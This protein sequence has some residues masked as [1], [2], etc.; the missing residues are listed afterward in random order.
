MSSCFQCPHC[1]RDNFKTERGLEQ[2][3]N[4]HSVCS[5]RQR[6]LDIP[7]ATLKHS[8]A[9]S[10]HSVTTKRCST[11]EYSSPKQKIRGGLGGKRFPVAKSAYEIGAN[12]HS[13]PQLKGSSSEDEHESQF[14]YENDFPFLDDDSAATEDE[15]DPNDD[16]NHLPV[17][18]ETLR[19]FQAYAAEGKQHFGEFT[20]QEKAGIKLM[21]T[22]QK[23]RLL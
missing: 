12:A 10:K 5:Q 22:L 8:F 16:Q 1:L 3:L 13:G 2:H 14:A 11:N 19:S 15:N 6:L 21:D 9:A 18:D 23:K 4:T 17:N 20:R 7:V